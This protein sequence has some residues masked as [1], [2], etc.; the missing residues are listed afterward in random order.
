MQ[1]EVKPKLAGLIQNN[2]LFVPPL[3]TAVT[4]EV[5]VWVMESQCQPIKA[6]AAYIYTFPVSQP[7]WSSLRTVGGASVL[8]MFSVHLPH[9]EK[10]DLIRQE[11]FLLEIPPKVVE[12]AWSWPPFPANSLLQWSK[13]GCGGIGGW[14]TQT[15]QRIQTSSKQPSVF[16]LL[17]CQTKSLYTAYTLQLSS[18]LSLLSPGKDGIRSGWGKSDFPS[19]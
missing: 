2:R 17:S 18:E 19:D 8:C 6:F 14:L 3:A 10:S 5:W 16:P 12:M 13:L 1:Y 9:Q 4:A 11:R 7:C 15:W